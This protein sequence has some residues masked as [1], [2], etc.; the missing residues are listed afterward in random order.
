[1]KSITIIFNQLQTAPVLK[2]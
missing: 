2:V 1:M